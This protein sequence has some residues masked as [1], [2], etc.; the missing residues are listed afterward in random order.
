MYFRTSQII[1][2]IIFGVIIIV[3]SGCAATKPVQRDATFKHPLIEEMGIQKITLLPI[4][5]HRVDKSL[6]TDLNDAG[7]Q[8]IKKVVEKRGFA[9]SIVTDQSYINGISPSDIA[10]SSQSWVKSLGPQGS[11]WVLLVVVKKLYRRI[12]FGAI[13]H[14]ELVGYLYDRNTGEKIWEGA[15]K[16]KSA[17]GIL[18]APFV[19]DHA[20]ELAAKSLAQGLP[21]NRNPSQEVAPQGSE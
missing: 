5:D 12:T 21:V 8:A 16:G 4:V 10:E 19:D 13:A 1:G 18:G 6:N 3:L 7:G 11:R 2:S 15:G 14:A 17:A 9:I 20:L